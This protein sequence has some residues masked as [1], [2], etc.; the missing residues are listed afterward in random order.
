MFEVSKQFAPRKGLYSVIIMAIL[1]FTFWDG[2]LIVS[3]VTLQKGK[4]P[5]MSFYKFIRETFLY[6][7]KTRIHLHTD[8]Q[9]LKTALKMLKNCLLRYTDTRPISKIIG[10][11]TGYPYIMLYYLILPTMNIFLLLRKN[12]FF[13]LKAATTIAKLS[14]LGE[15]SLHFFCQIFICRYHGNSKV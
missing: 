2:T 15:I 8:A 9:T 5:N 3:I 12:D 13:F 1:V 11:V 6:F 14:I 7:V 4:T 10:G